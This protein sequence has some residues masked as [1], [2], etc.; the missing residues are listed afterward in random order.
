MIPETF[1]VIDWPA[2]FGVRATPLDRCADARPSSI[3]IYS[4]VVLEF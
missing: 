3:P 1:E 2:I 4:K